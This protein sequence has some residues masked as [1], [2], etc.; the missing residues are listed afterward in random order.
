MDL[1]NLPIKNDM[2][3]KS[4]IAP[5][6]REWILRNWR[7]IGRK[8]ADRAGILALIC[9]Q[10]QEAS[11]IDPA[12]A[13]SDPTHF[14]GTLI[15]TNLIAACIHLARC[16]E[17]K[18]PATVMAVAAHLPAEPD[19]ESAAWTDAFDVDAVG[20]HPY[21][22]ATIQVK[23]S[24][25][26]AELHRTLKHHER[27]VQAQLDDINRRVRPRFRFADLIYEIE[28]AGYQPVDLRYSVDTAA[29]LQL[30]RC[31]PLLA[32]RIESNRLN[33]S[34]RGLRVVTGFNR[35]TEPIDVARMNTDGFDE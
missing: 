31:W 1:L 15:N 10:M 27:A 8:D 9:Q 30:F 18:S 11:N 26:D 4:D 29:A 6:S 22:S 2:Q 32:R 21:L 24:C 7:M 23:I 16:V 13:I 35:N 14:A 17:L 3:A 25:R 33:L 5:R 34:R 19:G 12:P 20:P 28:P